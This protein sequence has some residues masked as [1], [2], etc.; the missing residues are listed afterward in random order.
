MCG[1]TNYLPS[2]TSRIY[3][4]VKVEAIRAVELPL[5]LDLIEQIA[6]ILLQSIQI[7]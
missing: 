4:K 5:D 1:K 2:N 3:D 7:T 6:E